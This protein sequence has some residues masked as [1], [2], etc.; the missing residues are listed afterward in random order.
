MSQVLE[1][2]QSGASEPQAITYRTPC[3]ER[4]LG[5]I[6]V[7]FAATFCTGLVMIAIMMLAVPSSPIGGAIYMAIAL[8]GVPIGVLALAN[9][10]EPRRLVL[11]DDGLWMGGMLT[12]KTVPFERIALLKLDLVPSAI[13]PI[14]KLTIVHDR[15]EVF[16]LLERSEAVEC[17]DALRSLCDGAA[18]IGLDDAYHPPASP[19]HHIE[20]RQRLLREFSRRRSECLAL[21]IILGCMAISAAVFLT[22]STTA[23]AGLLISHI[24][25]AGLAAMCGGAIWRYMKISRT[26]AEIKSEIARGPT[27]TTETET[28]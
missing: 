23:L 28:P 13:N 11:R 12:G 21:A 4:L 9:L 10:S 2:P 25:G 18:A 20:G 17:F 22:L 15:R 27:P 14:G 26:I 16:V 1:H 8:I 24:I 5:A 19:D 6:K 7:S 3:W